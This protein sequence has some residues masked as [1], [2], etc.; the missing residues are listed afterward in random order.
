M[1]KP[2]PTAAT[3]PEKPA[4]KPPESP[5][6]PESLEP[7]EPEPEADDFDGAS[8][9]QVS[10]EGVDL[11]G[12]RVEEAE[13]EQCRLTRVGLAGAEIRH[14]T[15]VDSVIDH[16]DWANAVFESCGLRRLRLEENRMTGMTFI[17]GMVRD[18]EFRDSKLDLTNWRANTFTSVHF[19]RCDLSGADFNGAD[20]RGVVFSECGLE[21]AQFSNAK[22]NGARFLDCDLGGIGG[23]GSLAGATIR[24][25]DLLT[26]TGLLARELGITIE[27]T[28]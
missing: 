15:V 4:E 2:R 24:S 9:Y 8:W 16:G 14:L 22:A 3:D 7:L 1:P 17:D 5:R 11:S 13:I 28:A 27:A 18:V 26:L 6:M 21:G 23:I 25:G 10:L 20:L 12:A 19:A